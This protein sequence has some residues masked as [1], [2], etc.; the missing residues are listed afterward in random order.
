MNTPPVTDE[1][2]KI[3]RRDFLWLASISTAGFV[4]GCAT[5][6]V[7]G[8]SQLML[9]SEQQE[10]QIDKQHSPHQFSN[11]YGELQ[12]KKLNR[13]IQEI[14]NNMAAK[15]HRSQMPYSFRGVNATYV[16]AYAFP[17]GSI[18]VTRGILL[19]I[20]N[21]AELAGL[22]GHELGHVNARHSAEQMSK[23]M[24]SQAVI[25]GLAV[26]AGTQGKAYGQIASAIGMVGASALLAKYSRDNEREADA[27]GMEY[28]VRSG[29]H[30]NGLVDLMDM[31]KSMSKHQ[32]SMIEAMFTS[33]PMSDER[34]DTAVERSETAYRSAWKLPKNKER[35]MDKTANLR[36]MK[37][38]IEEMQKGQSQM[39]QKKYTDAEE[40]F[41]K[42]LKQAPNDYAGLVMMSKCQM[43]LNR[44]DASRRF[45][46]RAKSVNP[47]EAQAHQMSGFAKLQ[48]KNFNAAYNDFNRYDQLLPGNPSTSFYK[49]FTLEK[50][51]RK[52]AS[53]SEYYRYLQM[54]QQGDEATYAHQR[55]IQWGVVKP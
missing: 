34:Y 54:V 31:L 16:N 30:P 45:A 37:G 35:Y 39:A 3:T 5:N 12:D 38:A 55:L 52:K 32:P 9:M 29:Y 24:L 8:Q 10:V 4:L 6:P 26:Y 46:E 11:D 40:H 18:A 15:T 47:K 27:L 19:N 48:K 44:P 20:E 21:E 17:G 25:G 2:T 42:A 41:K 36:A 13:Y 53:A 22:L 28:M 1:I 51:G 50:M 23:G 43:A 33:H 7:T 14:G 49:G